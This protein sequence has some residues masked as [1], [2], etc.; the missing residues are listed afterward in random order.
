[1]NRQRHKTEYLLFL[2]NAWSPFYAGAVWPRES[3]LRALESS[4]SGQRLKLLVGDDFDVCENCTPQVGA[5]PDSIIKPDPEHIL[6]VLAE[7]SPRM[8]IACGSHAER[9][10]LELWD[11]PLLLIPHPAY[12]VVT[13]QMFE[14]AREYIGRLDCRMKLRQLRGSV[15]A[16]QI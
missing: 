2:Q 12:R 8:V 9:A 10:L 13:N 3:W 7:R 5:T 1:M 4:R 14:H 15:H 16:M 11:G 6:K